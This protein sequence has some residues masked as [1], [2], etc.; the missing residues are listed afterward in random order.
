MELAC[1]RPL[2][3]LS[4]AELEDLWALAKRKLDEQFE[5]K[6]GL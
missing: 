6:E 1:E 2:E 3:E 5:N 4:A